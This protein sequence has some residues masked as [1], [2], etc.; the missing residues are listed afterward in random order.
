MPHKAH[1][2]T[3]FISHQ[4][5]RFNSEKYKNFTTV[6]AVD[7]SPRKFLPY[8]RQ[9]AT[10]TMTACYNVVYIALICSGPMENRNT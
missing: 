10:T 7:A 9:S 8:N 3:F 2:L 5:E 1:Y 6:T 4:L